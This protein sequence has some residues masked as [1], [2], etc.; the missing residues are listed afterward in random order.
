MFADSHIAGIELEIFLPLLGMMSAMVGALVYLIRQ[1]L[2]QKDDHDV[3]IHE[4]AHIKDAVDKL[5]EEQE[6][7]QSKG[8]TTLPDDIG[9]SSALTETIRDLQHDA[10]EVDKKLDIVIGELREHV[11]WEMQEKYHNDDIST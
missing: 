5:V 11:A 8:W 6:Q 2:G 4:V 9:T 3:V 1:S 10:A 7:F